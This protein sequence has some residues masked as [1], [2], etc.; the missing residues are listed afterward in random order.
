VLCW[1]F[2]GVFGDSGFM[3]LYPASLVIRIV[4]ALS[5]LQFIA[6]L[7]ASANASITHIIPIPSSG[8]TIT[9]N[10]NASITVPPPGIA[11]VATEPTIA[12]NNTSP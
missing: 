10:T 5:P 1:G 4:Q 9:E 7:I 12:A 2:Y 3:S 8:S 6:V 11:A